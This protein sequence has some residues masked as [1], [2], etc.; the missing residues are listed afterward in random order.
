MKQD[1]ENQGTGQDIFVQCFSDFIF[2]FMSEEIALD[3][4]EWLSEIRKPRE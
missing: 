2:R 3:T 4:K 1:Y